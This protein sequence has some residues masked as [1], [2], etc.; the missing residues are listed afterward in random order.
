MDFTLAIPIY[1]LGMISGSILTLTATLI[2]GARSLKK[3]R[4]AVEE[5][6]KNLVSLKDRMKKVKELTED[7]LAMQQSIDGPQRNALDGKYKNSVIRKI[8]DM[9]EEK[10]NILVSIIQD[11]YDPELT[12]MDPSTGTVTQMKLSE[13]MSYM[14]INVPPKGTKVDAAKESKAKRLGKFTV[15]NGGKDDADD[16]KVH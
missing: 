16:G 14:G 12:A 4:E 10:N 1:V 7:I 6:K 2:I 13:Y 5:Q 15:I 8:K 11:G 3:K 9:D